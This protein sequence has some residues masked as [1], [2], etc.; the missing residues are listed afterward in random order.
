M[1]LLPYG[2]PLTVGSIAYFAWAGLMLSDPGRGRGG[3]VRGRAGGSQEV[4]R[5]RFR[6]AKGGDG[7]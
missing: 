1:T 3:S 2:I 4:H 7:R 5:Q 6:R